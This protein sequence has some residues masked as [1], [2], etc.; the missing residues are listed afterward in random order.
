M[1][2]SVSERTQLVK[3]KAVSGDGADLLRG[4]T[5]V[6]RGNGGADYTSEVG[7]KEAAAARNGV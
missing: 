6:P 2:D 4:A 1:G 7:Q 5:T 3:R